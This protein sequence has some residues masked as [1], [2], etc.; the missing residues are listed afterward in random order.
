MTRFVK[1]QLDDYI[2]FCIR[3]LGSIDFLVLQSQS[4]NLSVLPHLRSLQLIEIMLGRYRTTPS[5]FFHLPRW[6]AQ[7]GALSKNLRTAHGECFL[8]RNT[9]QDR[10]R[11][12]ISLSRTT[13]L[14][15]WRRKGLER[16]QP[17]YQSENDIR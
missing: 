10:S 11:R 15:V 17:A 3:V 14:H 12:R 16:P 9:S 1:V 4:T 8:S 2:I 6:S 7:R 13:R 5:V